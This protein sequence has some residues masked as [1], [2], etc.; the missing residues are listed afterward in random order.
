M[1]NS[2]QIFIKKT[3]IGLFS[4]TLLKPY[5]QLWAS[6]TECKTIVRPNWEQL[7]EVAHWY[8]L[9]HNL[10][11]QQVKVSSGRETAPFY[12]PNELLP[13]AT[14]NSMFDTGYTLSFNHLS[15][16]LKEL[17]I[18]AFE[19]VSPKTDVPLLLHYGKVYM[20]I[21]FFGLNIKNTDIREVINSLPDL[22]KI[23]NS[24]NL[25]IN[26]GNK[27]LIISLEIQNNDKYTDVYQKQ[28]DFFDNLVNINQAFLKAKKILPNNH[29]TTI[30]FEGFDANSF[31]KMISKPIK[32]F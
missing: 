19:L 17:N 4:I 13:T 16:I 12:N 7:M 24:Y 2:K 27:E 9:A 8:P 23:V 5:N 21:S 29:L 11:P 20:T 6:S 1:K 15:S 25:R 32:N 22:S 3:V 28:N 26:E 31:K 18:D 14:T 30:H 10:P